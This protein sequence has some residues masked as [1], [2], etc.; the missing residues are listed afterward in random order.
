LANPASLYVHE[1]TVVGDALDASISYNK[2]TSRRSVAGFVTFDGASG[3]DANASNLRPIRALLLQM[4]RWRAGEISQEL[5]AARRALSA[6][7][8]EAAG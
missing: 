1:I 6:C 7:A 8:R 3:P 5:S 2:S 4:L